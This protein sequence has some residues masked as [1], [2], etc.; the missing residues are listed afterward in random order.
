MVL[1]VWMTPALRLG[2]WLGHQGPASTA[3]AES[4]DP[5]QL[6]AAE[7]PSR[8]HSLPQKRLGL[9]LLKPVAQLWLVKFWVSWFILISTDL[10]FPVDLVFH[11]SLSPIHCQ[12]TGLHL[13]QASRP[14]QM[15]RA[16]TSGQDAGVQNVHTFPVSD[17]ANWTAAESQN[18]WGEDESSKPSRI[19]HQHDPSEEIYNVLDEI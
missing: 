4:P 14:R 12:V 9:G 10:R 15:S 6:P 17:A 11:K 7:G 2:P 5:Q 19:F 8:A 16:P 18:A 3:A 13:P 1:D